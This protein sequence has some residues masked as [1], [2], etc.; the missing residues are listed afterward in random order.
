MHRLSLTPRK[1]DDGDLDHILLRRPIRK[2][3]KK[4]CV[5]CQICGIQDFVYPFYNSD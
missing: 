3:R 4:T 5:H 1:R 2:E